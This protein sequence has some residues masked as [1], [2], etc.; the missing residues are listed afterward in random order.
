MH[1]FCCFQLLLCFT[2]SVRKPSRKARVLSAHG[3]W[4]L[5]L[6]HHPCLLRHAGIS[7]RPVG[8]RKNRHHPFDDCHHLLLRYALTFRLVLHSLKLPMA[9]SRTDCRLSPTSQASCVISSGPRAHPFTL[10]SMSRYEPLPFLLS[11]QC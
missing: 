8:S 7:H 1:F 4:L 9:H 10:L 2:F 6:V 5:W 11:T 3:Y